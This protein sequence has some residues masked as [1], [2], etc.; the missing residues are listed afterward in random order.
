MEDIYYPAKLNLSSVC[1]AQSL[2]TL[3]FYVCLPVTPSSTEYFHPL[4]LHLGRT[5]LYCIKTRLKSLTNFSMQIGCL[6]SHTNKN[7]FSISPPSSKQQIYLQQVLK[8]NWIKILKIFYLEKN[9]EIYILVNY[10]S[11]LKC[12]KYFIIF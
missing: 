6:Y 7:Y 5:T 3:S 1:P 10:R 12:H 8:H 11:L 9:I 2:N 4:I